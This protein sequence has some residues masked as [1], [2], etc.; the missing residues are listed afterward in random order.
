M[1]LK[2]IERSIIKKYRG[3]LYAPFIRA[4]QEYEMLKE[5]DK[6]AVCIS[7]GKD[8][9]LLAKLFQELQKHSDFPFETKYIVMDPGFK[10]ENV[11][12]LETNLKILGIDAIIKKSDIFDV[13]DKMGGEKPCY[14]CAR[15]RRGFLYEFAKNEGCNKIALGH[16]FDDVVETIMINM[17]YGAQYNTM[18]PKLKSTNFPGMELI[19]PMVLIKEKDIE[20]WVKYSEITPMKCAC[21]V[22]NGEV[23]SKRKEVKELIKKL[24]KVYDDV[25]INIFRSAENVN[26]NCCLGWK[27]GDEYHS[28]LEDYEKSNSNDN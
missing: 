21:R 23:E 27:K 16:H 15:M 7:G 20:S 14:L 18:M 19:R 8:S 1:E 28:F 6:V 22:S 17:L 11:E 3:K 5:G 12:A 13:A 9:L 10:K 25:D 26:L 4:L 24:K 2:E